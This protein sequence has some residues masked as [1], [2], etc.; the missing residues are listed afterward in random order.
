V[1]GLIKLMGGPDAFVERLNQ[2]YETPMYG[3][4]RWHQTA[5]IPDGTGM[6]GQ[7]VMGNEQGFHIPYFYVYAG[8]PW[9]TQK[10]LRMLMDTWFRNDLM[11]I[12]GDE[13]GGGMSAWYVFSAM[14]FYPVTPGMPVYT[15]GTPLFEEMSIQ[16]PNDK[17]L[18]IIARNNSAQNK[19]IQS[20]TLNGE[21]LKNAW[22]THQ[23]IVDGGELVFDMGPRPNKAWGAAEAPPSLRYL[24]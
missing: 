15:I 2:L 1:A 24:K 7:F 13:D 5:D 4:C 12:C 19:Y 6:V 16:L 14:G 3:Y 17:K 21:P 8:Q 23:D 22:F 10:R 18:K 9:R 11:G 20:A